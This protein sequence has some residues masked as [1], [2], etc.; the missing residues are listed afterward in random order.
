MCLNCNEFGNNRMSHNMRGVQE[1]ITFESIPPPPNKLSLA[2]I[3]PDLIE[4]WDY[5]H[6]GNLKPEQFTP[7]SDRKIWWKCKKCGMCWEAKICNR[8]I[9]KRG[10]PYDAGHKPI[11]GKTDLVTLYPK[12]AIEWDYALN[13]DLLPEQFTAKSARKVWW[14]CKNCGES[15]QATISSRVWGHGC[16]YDS[17]RRPVPGKTD[18][19]TVYPELASEWDYALNCDLLPEQFT[20]KSARKVWWKCKNCGESWQATI[21]SRVWGRGCP[22]DSGRRPIPGKTDLA[23]MYPELASEWDYERNDTLR[24]EHFTKCSGRKVWWKCKNCGQSW[25]STIANRVYRKYC[26]YDLGCKPIPGKTDLATLCPTLAAEWDYERNGKLYPE[27]FTMGSGKKVWWKCK[28]CGQSWV[29]E[30]R[31]RVNGKGCSCESRKVNK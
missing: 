17:G 1:E 10:C 4:E 23:T 5:E 28:L 22:Y 26:P 24:P 12:L 18:L 2:D 25:E 21:S 13:C 20:A 15:W 8:T 7:G 31:V 3:R 11:P 16:P 14:K 9:L 19:A 27:N 29:S 30:I 6:N